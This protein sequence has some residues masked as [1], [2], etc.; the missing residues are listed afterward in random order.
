MTVLNYLSNSVHSD[1]TSLLDWNYARNSYLF[2]LAETY[3]NLPRR[4]SS[5]SNWL[6]AQVALPSAVVLSHTTLL[7]SSTIQILYYHSI[8][9]SFPLSFNPTFFSLFL[10]GF[11]TPLVTIQNYFYTAITTIINTHSDLF[12]NQNVLAAMKRGMISTYISVREKNMKLLM[13]AA[14]KFPRLLIT[15]YHV[16]VKGL[17]DR[18][19][20]VRKVSYHLLNQLC[21]LLINPTNSLSNENEMMI[22]KDVFKL[23]VECLLKE[24]EK[25][26]RAIAYEIVCHC[27][28]QGK[29]DAHAFSYLLFIC[30]FFLAR[31]DL[32]MNENAEKITS[33]FTL[34]SDL[35]EQINADHMTTQI[36]WILQHHFEQQTVLLVL[37]A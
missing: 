31:L 23:A 17:K 13:A 9:D 3:A 1:K 21:Q 4:S 8:R 25:S 20:S 12:L 22:A 14:T 27:L 7:S 6:K 32:V 19:V 28:S 35:H 11:D 33:S 26:V 2:V 5:Y 36:Q 34:L 24:E 18:G 30:D 10:R 16:V 29:R 15:Y 37:F